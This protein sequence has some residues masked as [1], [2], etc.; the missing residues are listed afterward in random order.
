M[1][2]H[3]ETFKERILLVET[4]PEISDL[5]YRQ[6]LQPMG[7]KVDV[8]GAAPA[9]IQEA[10]RSKPDVIL[11]DLNLPGLSGKDLLVALSSQG[12]DVPIIVI[13]PQG[14]ES[15]VIQAFRLGATDFIAC[16]IREAQVVSAVERVLRQ[17][18]ARREREHLARQLNQTNQELQR[19][20]RE[21]TTIL[22]IGKAVVSTTDQMGLFDK[23]LEGAAFIAEADS[24]WLLSRDEHTKSFTLR[25]CRN[26]PP[27]IYTRL[28]QPF[29]DGISS[30]VALSG[31]T[32]NIHGAPMANFKVSRMGQSALVVPIKVKHEVVG[33]LVSTRK[34][35]QPF[36]PSQQVLLESV[37]DYA[38]ISL[39][40]A[41]LFKALEER[42]ATLQQ[43]A[44]TVLL[45]KRIQTEILHEYNYEINH[46]LPE[47]KENLHLMSCNEPD[48][49][50]ADQIQAMLSIQERL[51]TLQEIVDSMNRQPALE[52]AKPHV[53]VDLTGITRQAVNRFQS[54]ARHGRSQIQADI[55]AKAVYV[56]AD[57]AQI[58]QVL[59]GL[60]SNAVK[61]TPAG[62]QIQLLLEA[63]AE[64]GYAPPS[65]PKAIVAAGPDRVIA[66]VAET[67]G[68]ATAGVLTPVPGYFRAV[69]E[70]ENNGVVVVHIVRPEGIPRPGYPLFEFLAALESLRVRAYPLA[71]DGEWHLDVAAQRIHAAWTEA[72]EY[73][74]RQARLVYRSA[75][76]GRDWF[77]EAFQADDSVCRQWA[78]NQTEWN[79]NQTANENLAGGAIVGGALGAASGALIG[80]AS[81][82][83]GPGAAIGAGAGLLGGAALGSNQAYGAGGEVQRRYDNAYQ[84]CMYAKGNQIPGQVQASNRRSAR[85][86]NPPPPPPPPTYTQGPAPIPPPPAG[87]PPPPPP[88]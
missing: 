42:L 60:L 47:I 58:S 75:E 21:L 10:I 48:K 2:K 37:A 83:V 13:A 73:L 53:V 78:Q 79:A 44:D 61:F 12:I 24:A 3:M 20:V 56:L 77:F 72:P 15:D 70:V 59:D 74:R 43:S 80:A 63:I 34:A 50:S 40:N 26:V 68:G 85:W 25:A 17:G 4:D 9:A 1:I 33:L 52:A 55:P 62:T 30:L 35:A 51:G 39:V 14:M 8:V 87:P 19:R 81:G 66:F 45:D 36:T 29:D 41:R 31:E 16:P 46:L 32:L 7:Y 49:L 65:H 28:N 22:A 84:Q 86:A 76:Y 38:S 71:H 5:I 23:I 27:D 64:A 88:R 54:I 18:R 11:A 6:T 67:V 69:R 82:N 57:A